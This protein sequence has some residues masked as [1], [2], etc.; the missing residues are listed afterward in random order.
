MRASERRFPPRCP[1]APSHLPVVFA[2][3]WY[4]AGASGLVAH[5]GKVCRE[6]GRLTSTGLEASRFC[7][8]LTHCMV[9]TRR[10]LHR[11]LRG[12]HPI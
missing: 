4:R 7:G 2:L 8:P 9:K 1:A 6:L 11:F 10:P 3:P 5:P 12:L